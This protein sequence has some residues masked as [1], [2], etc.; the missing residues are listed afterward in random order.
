M[1]NKQFFERIELIEYYLEGKTIEFRYTPRDP[2]LE[3]PKYIEP[4]DILRLSN[5]RYNFRIKE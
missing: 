3:I 1:T 2:W 5:P 4:G